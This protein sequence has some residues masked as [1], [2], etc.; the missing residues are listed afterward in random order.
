MLNNLLETL[1]TAMQDESDPERVVEAEKLAHRFVR[2]VVRIFSVVSVGIS[3][4]AN[5]K[6]A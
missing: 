4:S 1:V 3:P 5:R 2:S 6:K